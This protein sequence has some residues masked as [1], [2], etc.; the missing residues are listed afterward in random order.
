MPGWCSRWIRRFMLVT[1]LCA[2]G[3][4]AIIGIATAAED[5]TLE[6]IFRGTINDTWEIQLT[7]RSTEPISGSYFYERVKKPIPL[8]AQRGE[9]G[10]W[11]VTEFDDRKN[12]T[13]QFTGDIF[14][15]VFSGTWMNEDKS[16]SYPFHLIE[17]HRQWQGETSPYRS[18]K[19]LVAQA[20]KGKRMRNSI[21]HFSFTL[22]KAD[23]IT[24]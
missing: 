21:W 3:F 7:L 9:D 24:T 10:N 8:E 23:C 16:K 1:F 2:L 20:R 14:G 13:G 6:R 22:G 17:T 5:K 12:G 15:R 18:T 4:T 19:P 11:I